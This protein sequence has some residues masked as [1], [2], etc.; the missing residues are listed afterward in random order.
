MSEKV[1]LFLLRFYPPHF[2]EAY[3]DEALQL[4]RDRARDEQGPF[5]KLRLWSDLLIDFVISLPREYRYPALVGAYSRGRL[6]G[7]PSF[8]LLEG[9]SPPP[10]AFLLG[11]VFSLAALATFPAWITHARNNRAMSNAAITSLAPPTIQ[12]SPSGTTQTA[13]DN[14]ALDAAAKQRV[15]DAV[16]ANVNQHYFDRDAAQRIGDALLAHQ[17]NGDDATA[18]SGDA[19]ANLLTQQLRAVSHDMHLAV[20]YSKDK[21]SQQPVQPTPERVAHLRKVMEKENCMFKKVEILPHNIGYLKLDFFPDTSLCKATAKTA[22]AALNHA[23]AVIFDLR[24]NTGGFQDMVSFIA[25]YLFDHPEYMYSP[26]GA[27][28]VDSWT[29]SPVPGNKLADKPVYILTSASTWS[30]AEQFSY[31]LKMLKRA[32]LVGETTRGGAHAGVFH[33]IDDHF[34]IGIPEEKSINPFSNSDWEGV[35]V[36]PD[37]KVKAPDALSAAVRLAEARIQMK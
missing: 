2:R 3:G 35:G 13:S 27:L 6:A 12:S 4:F 8:H 22:M 10:S 14:A 29:R 18:A 5:S 30:G 24:E 23:D 37:V 34:G 25:S 32:T 36:Q 7:V 28:T 19:L 9:A 20:L 33:R 26:R 11:T 15:V 21:L 17:T 16:I 1:Y 31:D